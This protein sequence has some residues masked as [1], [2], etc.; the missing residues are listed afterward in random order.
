MR[1]L[2]LRELVSW[3]IGLLVVVPLVT[4][5]LG[6]LIDR[7][8]RTDSRYVRTAELFRALLLPAGI[9][10]L[11]ARQ[12]LQLEADSG[13]FRVAA[14]IFLL[15]S[16]YI[17]FL[18]FNSVSQERDTQRWENRVPGLFKTILQIAIIV[19]PLYLVS[20][21]W[22]V[23]L[24]SF[25]AALGIGTIAIA[26][27]LQDTLSSI[28]SGFLLVIDKPFA[29]GDWIEIDGHR[30]KVIDISWR[31]T[32]LQISQH[33]VVVIPNLNIAGSSVYNLT[34]LDIMYRDEIELGFSYDDTPSRVK[35]T[36]IE[37]VLDCPHVLKVPAPKVHTISYNDFAI[38]YR[39]YYYVAEFKGVMHQADIRDDVMTRVYYAVERNGLSM[40]FPTQVEGPPELFETDNK[41]VEADIL[42]FLKE[43]R[44]FSRLEEPSLAELAQHA[45]V[46]PFGKDETILSEGVS[47]QYFYLVRSGTIEMIRNDHSHLN[48]HA[49]RLIIKEGDILG[50][51]SLMGKRANLATSV[52]LDDVVLYKIPPEIINAKLE[53]NP[54]FALL[55]NRLVEERIRAFKGKPTY[56]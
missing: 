23:D 33:D 44:Y 4:I 40:P 13:P 45:Y 49:E 5:G 17:G 30:G 29:V 35:A 53:Q 41:Q 25:V 42:H 7:L 3:A 34:M 12:L 9:A 51:M 31:S 54:R 36:L 55:L 28:V 19:Y 18:F 48:G 47:C 22:G 26:F 16:A 52:S 2:E 56:G 43:N 14:T 1:L 15:V 10:F 46:A 11:I 8:R 20:G 21:V 32:R 50:E 39:L 37:M 38:V 24:S 6:E 27:A